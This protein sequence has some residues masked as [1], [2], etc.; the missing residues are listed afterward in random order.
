MMNLEYN[1][2]RIQE[3]MEM[4]QK[5]IVSRSNE[6]R[7]KRDLLRCFM[8][9]NGLDAIYIR[10]KD[11]FSWLTSGAN[12]G[13]VLSTQIGAAG[14]LLTANRQYVV[15]S[16]I[17]TPRL[18]KEEYLQ[19]LGFEII[20]TDWMG[21]S[22]YDKALSLAHSSYIYSDMALEQQ[23]NVH[24]AL[25][26]L[27]Y[28]LTDG[29][30]ARY[31]ALGALASTILEQTMSNLHPK[32]SELEI[33][34]NVSMNLWSVGIEPVNLLCAVDE[35]IGKYRHP[36][37][38]EKKLKNLC[39]VSLGARYAGLIVSLTRTVSF[40]RLPCIIEE[41]KAASDAV[42]EKMVIQTHYG[43]PVS[44]ILE[45]GMC[46]YREIGYPK[47]FQKHHQGGA[48]G[49]L[50]R[51][52][53]VTPTSKEVVQRNQGFCWNPTIQGIK[54]E[55]TILTQGENII[56]ITRPIIFPY[57]EIIDGKSTL[58]IPDILEQ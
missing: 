24:A 35:R 6:S 18:Q 22:D 15:A 45:A 58:R 43:T 2:N 28:S 29:E 48:I 51:E 21:Q 25:I 4:M 34:A 1:S 8:N 5:D 50:P 7:A 19:E 36:M 12:N 54:N 31:T 49:Y 16:N 26:S 42:F 14:I 32:M 9:E 38:T 52:Y 27:R 30:I 39:M 3:D 13:G 53:K 41:Q 44:D 40:G 57:R 37:P 46:C 56:P 33:V 10:H 20:S 55:D 47:E 23:S 17:E 11:S